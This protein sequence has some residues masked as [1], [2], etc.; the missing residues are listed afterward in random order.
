MIGVLLNLLS[1]A[2]F[3]KPKRQYDLKF[4]EIQAQVLFAGRNSSGSGPLN[5]SDQ[6][7]DRSWLTAHTEVN[8]NSS[9]RKAASPE[10]EVSLRARRLSVR[11]IKEILR[12][13][14]EVGLGLRQIARTCAIG[15][16]IARVFT[17]GR[18]CQDHMAAWTRVG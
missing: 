13:K 14:F 7:A 3:C 10:R 12:L 11:K 18:S 8:P 16:G 6:E 1:M 17:A 9:I 4:E 15:P 5:I 2:G